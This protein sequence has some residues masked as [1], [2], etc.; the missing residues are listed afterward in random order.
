MVLASQFE[1]LT[2]PF[3]VMIAI[4]FAMS[5][6]FIALFLTGKT[7]SITS[8]LGLIMLV[9]IVV[10]NSILIIEFIRQ[11]KDTMDRDQALVQAG[12][13]RLRPI[14]MTT[15]TTCVGMIPLSLG[16]S[17]GGEMMSPLGVSIIGGL[18]GSTAVTLLLVPV[19]YAI[20]DD[21]RNKRIEKKRRREA[22]IHQ[23]IEKWNEEGSHGHA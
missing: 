16:F 21:S 17:D 14:L 5:G 1:S 3:I 20:A 13:T 18:L 15:L 22:E 6:S 23:L 4:P 19:L 12:K 7:L 8:F 9:G 11:N 2:Q 10:N